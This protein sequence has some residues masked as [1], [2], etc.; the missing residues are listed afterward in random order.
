MLA[1]MR[2]IGID[3]GYDRIGIAVLEKESGAETL[4]FSTCIETSRG[5]SLAER[6]LDLG[7]RFEEILRTYEPSLLGIET[8]FFNRNQK[9]AIGVAQARGI[10]LFLGQKWRCELHEF[11]PQEIKVAITGYGK[12]DKQAVIDMVKRLVRG[13]PESA[14]DDE[15]DA[16]AAGITCL[17]HYRGSL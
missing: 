1:S 17:A 11:S 10:L 14:L 9:T 16:I 7:E 6:L 15:Y 2:V 4:L 8:L 12:S 5:A 3:P 13:A